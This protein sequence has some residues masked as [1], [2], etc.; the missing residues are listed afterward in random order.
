MFQSLSSIG[1]DNGDAAVAG[2][3][4]DSAV[5]DA[6]ARVVVRFVDTESA[7]PARELVPARF[8]GGPREVLR[9][10]VR[11]AQFEPVH[12]LERD[13]RV[14]RVGELMRRSALDGLPQV[15]TILCV[16]LAPV[17]RRPIRADG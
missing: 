9:D 7:P 5:E 2:Q 3:R 1:R 13:P 17:G 6:V 11:R 8:L 14:T 12:K 4:R 16:N 15:F 10:R